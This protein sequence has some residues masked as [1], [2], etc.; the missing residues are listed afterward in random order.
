M[1]SS[2]QAK[3][4]EIE[5]SDKYSDKLSDKYSDKLSDKLGEDLISEIPC[6][7]A[8]QKIVGTSE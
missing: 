5:R 2:S 8:F 7:S 1:T 3:Q 4:S 6:I